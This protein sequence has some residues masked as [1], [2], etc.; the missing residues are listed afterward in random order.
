MGFFIAYGKVKVGFMGNNLG[1]LT[2][3]LVAKMGGW[4]EGFTKAE[5]A[6]KAETR[7]MQRSIKDVE[8]SVK[9]M[10]ST[11][12]K[13]A[14]LLGVTLSVRALDGW[15]RGSIQA[16]A[17]TGD[18]AKKIGTTT[19]ELT[20]LRYIAV[21]AG[22]SV[23][24]L[25]GSMLRLN[26]R[27]GA[28][29]ISGGPAAKSLEALKLNS[30]ELMKMPLAEK[31][32]AIGDAMQGLDRE[33]QL[34]HLQNMAGDSARDLVEMFNMSKGQMDELAERAEKLGYIITTETANSAVTVLAQI[35]DIKGAF[36]NLSNQILQDNLPAIEEFLSSITVEDIERSMKIARAVV[37]N[38]GIAV[39]SLAA[40]YGLQLTG[41]MIASTIATIKSTNAKI[42]DIAITKLQEGATRS[43]AI[44]AGRHAVAMNAVR[45]SMGAFG[46][47]LGIASLAAVSFLAFSVSTKKAAISADE[48][49]AKLL[50][51]EQTM[52]S[53]TANQAVFSR[54]QLS[55]QLKVEQEL[56]AKYQAELESAEK[57]ISKIKG[58]LADP[59]ITA[60]RKNLER[61]YLEIA[62]RAQEEFSSK[63]DTTRQNIAKLGGGIQDL[64]THIKILNGA[65]S[66]TGNSLNEGFE[67]L[68]AQIQDET[69][70]IGLKSK[71]AVFEYELE[72]GV[73][74]KD[75]N[76]EQI[77]DLRKLFKEQDDAIA[78]NKTG[79]KGIN[80]IDTYTNK[81]GDLTDETARLVSLNDQLSATGYESKYNAFTAI[82]HEINS[83]NSGLSKLSATQQ[84][85]LMMKA[86]ELDSQKQINAIL[87]LG[88]DYTQKIDDL[89][90]EAEIYGETRKEIERLTFYRDLDTQ[91][92]LISIGMSEE[93]I[94]KLEEEIQKI[95]ELYDL[96]QDKVDVDENDPLAG[97]RK[98]VNDFIDSFGSL[99]E[100][101]ADFTKN[102]FDQMGDALAD[103][104]TTG[105]LDF[106]ELTRS[107]LSDLAKMMIK[108]AMVNAMKSWI[109]GY[110]EGGLVGMGFSSGGFTGVGGKYD[111]AGIVHKNEYVFSKQAVLSLGASNLERLHQ[112]GKAG[113]RGL[114]GYAEG[115]LVGVAPSFS[116]QSTFQ[117]IQQKSEPIHLEVIVNTE[118]GSVETNAPQLSAKL[119]REIET[120]VD[121]R[122][123]HHKNRSGGMLRGR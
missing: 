35:N 87:A 38:L 50:E 115:G 2:L 97:I 11:L 17:T 49:D 98:G 27:L 9:S 45:V 91:A 23:G 73:K 85:I 82:T 81:L 65:A 47:P 31:I 116:A 105:K 121:L 104:V 63:V 83:Q 58:R 69:N 22:S 54:R 3:D 48:L 107:I 100:Q 16:A 14:G 55:D 25:D 42:R 89:K 6:T 61:G 103:F 119:K 34:R 26:S 5:R 18:F 118:D 21:Q 70:R 57:E 32:T 108:M 12:T 13:A 72:L 51:L 71:S 88:S 99:R 20:A 75:L 117:P 77:E 4:V 78:S 101:M 112:A 36:G 80:L 43:A 7:K 111:E 109:G 67:K 60:D 90:F 76:P 29:F 86:Q 66:N 44:A 62:I 122:V 52:S 19:E 59:N 94:Q 120:T 92:K 15:V 93:N 46:G 79:S 68:K 53:M 123:S 30:N 74:Y 37:E 113:K 96:Y 114:L 1:T 40:A 10:Q 41:K 33:V 56:L 95:R 64:T 106:A 28:D 84:E 24:A 102:T 39:K 8:K 110:S